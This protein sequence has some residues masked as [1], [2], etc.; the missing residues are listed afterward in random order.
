[1]LTGPLTRMG[2]C[3][4]LQ[5]TI[6]GHPVVGQQIK[7]VIFIETNRPT[8]EDY[9]IYTDLDC[10]IPTAKTIEIHRDGE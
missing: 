2:F 7:M 4:L 5:A 9:G 6:V 1:M 10:T 3:L 8:C